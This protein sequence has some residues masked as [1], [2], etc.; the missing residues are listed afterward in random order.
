MTNYDMN[1]N[2][3][4]YDMASVGHNNLDNNN[5]HLLSHL[6]KKSFLQI[7]SIFYI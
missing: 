6:H 3:F 1:Y 5:S 4:V 7:D 2:E